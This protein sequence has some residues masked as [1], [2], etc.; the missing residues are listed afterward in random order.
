MIRD[1]THQR[2]MAMELQ[3]PRGAEI[4][5]AFKQAGVGIVAAL[6]DIWTSQGLLWPL[7]RDT[8]IRLLRVCKEDEGISICAGLSFCDQRAVML[9]QYTGLL[10]SINNIRASAVDYKLPVCMVVGLLQKEPDKKPTDSK[11]YGIRIVEPILDAMGVDRILIEGSEDVAKLPP[12]IA[13][14]YANSRPMAAL[15]GREV[16]E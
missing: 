16:R 2:G 4:I 12:A 3:G 10:D 1:K 5:A 14:A 11:R 7:S 9:M 13:K 6:P 8:D 15:I